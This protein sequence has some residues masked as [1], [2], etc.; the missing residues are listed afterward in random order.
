M[1][2]SRDS[3]QSHQ[4]FKAKYDLPF[5]LLADAAGSV[6][7][8]FGSGGRTTFLIDAKGTIQKV[9]PKVSVEGHAADV[10]QS[11]P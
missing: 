8:A 7:A 2:I 5:P 1:G 6:G 9:W 3:V 4:K 10:L 11:L